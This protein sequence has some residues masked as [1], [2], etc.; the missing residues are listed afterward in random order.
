MRSIIRVFVVSI[1]V[2]IVGCV[3][4]DIPMS[5]PT[6]S[7][8]FGRYFGHCAGD[9]YDVFILT[10]SSLYHSED[11][12]YPTKGIPWTLPRLSSMN[13]AEK[14]IAT[15]LRGLF[16]QALLNKNENV[17]GCVD[18]GDFGAVY[19]ELNQ[20]GNKRFWYIDN[21]TQDPELKNFV[22]TVHKK[23]D[24]IVK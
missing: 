17:I 6:D 18:C 10:S 8:V 16:P 13:D 7:F 3:N 21:M 1:C 5:S 2:I 14:N 19:I 23:I 15:E 9:C 12:T 22:V 24:L 4:H 11:E 20:N